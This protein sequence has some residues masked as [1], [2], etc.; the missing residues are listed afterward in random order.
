M[1][2]NLKT[3][4]RDYSQHIAIFRDININDEVLINIIFYNFER[5]LF[6]L[7]SIRRTR[8]AFRELS[9]RSIR[10]ATIIF[11][12]EYLDNSDLR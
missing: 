1:A 2:A 6:R 9:A 10:T 12:R 3:N 11:R 5:R 7:R 8:R 4:E